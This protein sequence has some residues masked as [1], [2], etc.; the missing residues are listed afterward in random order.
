MQPAAVWRRGVARFIDLGMHIAVLEGA[1]ALA[2]QL[3]V[4]R[5]LFAPEGDTLLY[6]DLFFGIGA[7]VLYAAVSEAWGGVTLGKILAQIRV[8]PAAGEGPLGVRAAFTRNL[9]LLADGFLF[10]LVGYSAIRR[11]PTQQRVGDVW[12]GT[13]VVNGAAPALA[14]LGPVLGGLAAMALLLV[15]YLLT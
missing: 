4:R 7:M 13:R 11:S 9:G 1:G 6:I 12:A 15:S 10:G 5:L 3:P 8:V 14:W 2:D